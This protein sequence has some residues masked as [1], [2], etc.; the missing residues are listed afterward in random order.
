MCFCT[1]INLPAMK[2]L[3]FGNIT[4]MATKTIWYFMYKN[5]LYE[6]LQEELLE[7]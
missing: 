4:G 6:Q 2:E 7:Q 5:A 1:E 3:L